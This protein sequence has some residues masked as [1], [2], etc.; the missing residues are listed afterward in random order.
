V[1][2]GPIDIGNESHFVESKELTMKSIKAIGLLALCVGLALI[3]PQMA[4][5][6]PVEDAEKV[7]GNI[8]D[9]NEKNLCRA[10]TIEKARTSNQ[11]QNRYQNKNHSIYYCSILKGRDAQNYCYAV[12]NQN[13]S[14]CG[15]IVD[16]KLEADCNSKVK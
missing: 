16:S 10:F 3:I 6:G 13:K 2:A 4:V 11:K 14:Q 9:H 7:C 5:A 12:V 15:E 8:A 1:T